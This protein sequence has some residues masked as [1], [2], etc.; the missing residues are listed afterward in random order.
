MER[1]DKGGGGEERGG[2]EERGERKGGEKFRIID[3]EKRGGKGRKRERGR[4]RERE[5]W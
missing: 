5:N 3:E 1:D 4:E 2:I